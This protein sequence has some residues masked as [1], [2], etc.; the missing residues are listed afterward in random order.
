MAE[1]ELRSFEGTTSNEWR[2]KSPQIKTATLA[3][4]ILLNRLPLLFT[5]T[6]QT[7]NLSGT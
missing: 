7:G 6:I 4:V 5:R 1:G 2:S 3:G